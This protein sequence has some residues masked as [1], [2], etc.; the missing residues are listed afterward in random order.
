[1]TGASGH[2][3]TGGVVIDGTGAEPVPA[4]VRLCDGIVAEIAPPGSLA[5]RSGEQIVDATDR[6]IVPGFVDI[7]TH[8]DFSLPTHP[9]AAS[10]VRQGVTTLVVG[11]CGFSPFPV[12]P[13]EHAEQL[14]QATAIFG[15]GLDWRWR[16]LPGYAAHL[17]EV[18]TAVNVAA[19]VGHGA[20]RIAV[21]GYERRDAT[22]SELS[23]M[24]HLVEGAMAA[25][26][27]GISSGLI[28]PPGSFAGRDELVQL[29][30][31][32]ADHGGIYSTHM[33][34]EGEQLLVALDEAMA[35]ARGSGV[36]LQLSHHKVL[37]RRNWG[38]TEESLQRVDA[39][40]AEGVDIALDQ[41]PYPASS[42]T[43]LAL[44]PGWA[45]EG[46][47]SALAERLRDPQNRNVIRTEILDGPTDGRPKRDFEPDT[48][49][50]SSVGLD[51]HSSFVGRRLD[52][53]AREAGR[54]PVDVMLDLL[55]RDGAVEVVIFAIGDEDIERVMRH[56]R[57]AIASDGWTL[58]PDEGGT[59]HPRSYGTFARVLQRYVREKNLLSLPEAVRRMTS[60]PADRLGLADRGR[61][62]AG[63]VADV[64][65][66]DPARV[67]ERATFV[68]P[69]QYAAG[70][71]DVFVAGVP[72]VRGGV[73]TGARPG[74]VLRHRRRP[75]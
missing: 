63:A 21:L 24:R 52:E 45:A 6:A 62:A 18:G 66:L 39:A 4:D 9:S 22:D 71:D 69:H 33:R 17:A 48:V 58:H 13:G 50:I 27:F 25:G 28:Y 67:T 30:R 42:T 61:I 64:V 60:L 54:E 32:V 49:M 51:E 11:N 74:A 47:A 38:L 41:Y 15:R 31:V 68:D 1:M 65:V 44:V 8:A 20:V 2:V 36:R 26:A 72:V 10:M 5:A 12:G 57:V 35:I 3:L 75:A 55:G 37:G 29:C 46:G 7:H 23:A 43:M 73:E 56:P 16:D 40:I 53:I 59:P 19:L 34:N 14:R 70:V